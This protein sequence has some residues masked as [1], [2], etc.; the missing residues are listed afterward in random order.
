MSTLLFISDKLKSDLIC[1]RRRV[2]SR[3]LHQRVYQWEEG[4]WSR[5][6]GR[7][8]LPE[9]TQDASLPSEP[10][11]Q[12]AAWNC[13]FLPLVEGRESDL[14]ALGTQG[15]RWAPRGHS[16]PSLPFFIITA[17]SR[18]PNLP[19][20]V[21]KVHRLIYCQ[22]WPAAGTRVEP[23]RSATVAGTLLGRCWDPRGTT[24]GRCWVSSKPRLRSANV[25]ER[26]YHRH[27]VL[28]AHRGNARCFFVGETAS[29]RFDVAGFHLRRL[30]RAELE[31]RS[32]SVSSQ[33]RRSGQNRGTSII[34][35]RPRLQRGLVFRTRATAHQESFC[36]HTSA[37]LVM[38]NDSCL[39]VSPSLS[40]TR[41]I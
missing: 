30:R 17:D 5:S 4:A 3:R 26:Q 12:S 13:C 16:G 28:S 40:P 18:H 19:R 31:P 1:A 39:Q 34:Q 23:P 22:F 36:D 9:I 10:C 20:R 41:Q 11:I 8:P 2:P 6:Q 14:W 29:W 38:V 7:Q 27:V 15:P 37:E 33:T 21:L 35:L 24:P 25:S 32:S